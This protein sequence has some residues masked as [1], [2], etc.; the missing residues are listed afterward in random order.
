MKNSLKKTM[1]LVFTALTLIATAPMLTVS[2][3]SSRLSPNDL[4]GSLITVDDLGAE[5]HSSSNTLTITAKIK[6]ISHSI[7]RGYATIYL[8]SP[9]G[10]EVST[11]QE[12]VNDGEGFAHGT[13][14]HFE[15]TSYVPEI[16]KV[17]S[18]SVDFTQN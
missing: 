2:N 10:E 17:G 7:L 13:T 4:N 1:C 18:I 9:N 12:E 16:N 6:N 8:L 5:F 11:Y 3:S 15:A 14:I